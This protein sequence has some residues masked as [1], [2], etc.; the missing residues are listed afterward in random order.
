MDYARKQIDI[1]TRHGVNIFAVVGDPNPQ[2]FA[3]IKQAG[4]I[5]VFRQLTPT[6]AGAKQAAQWGAD[7]L[8]ATG[9]DEGGWIPD[10]GIGT[11]SIV[12]MLAD[13]VSIPVMAAGGINDI[14]TV[15]AAFSLGAQG[16]YI[17]T[18]VIFPSSASRMPRKA[19]IS[20]AVWSVGWYRKNRSKSKRTYP[21]P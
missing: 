19:I 6:V 10:N 14:R 18:R 7:V 21:F 1:A 2:L 13:A 3:A 5:I 9:I 17:G 16:V 12:P 8:V 4:G 15:R 11:F 20:V